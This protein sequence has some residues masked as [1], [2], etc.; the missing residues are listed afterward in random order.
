VRDPPTSTFSNIPL[1][2]P[3]AP[4]LAQS[5]DWEVRRGEPRL[6]AVQM[7]LGAG[8][9]RLSAATDIRCRSTG[10]EKKKKKKKNTPHYHLL[11]ELQQLC[12]GIDPNLAESK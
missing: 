1:L 5:R 7:A 8:R 6:A 4:P 12:H 2:P 9:G 3:P 11:R 10:A